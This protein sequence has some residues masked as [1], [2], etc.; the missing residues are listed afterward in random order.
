MGRP[1]N[2]LVQAQIEKAA[3]AHINEKINQIET[4]IDY[5]IDSEFGRIIDNRTLLN[6]TI[7]EKIHLSEA[8]KQK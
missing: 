7:E 1:K 5:L 3:V 4:E 2:A 8:L 6:N